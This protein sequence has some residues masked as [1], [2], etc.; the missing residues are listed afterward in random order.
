MFTVYQLTT[1]NFEIQKQS[2]MIQIL[3][4]IITRPTPVKKTFFFNLK[5]ALDEQLLSKH[6]IIRL[7]LNHS[8]LFPYVYQN[9]VSETVMDSRHI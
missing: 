8:Y 5:A 1:Q 4:N 2:N 6:L 9:N 3:I 7:K